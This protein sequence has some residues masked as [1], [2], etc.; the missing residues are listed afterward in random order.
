MHSEKHDA[1]TLFRDFEA[2]EKPVISNGIGQKTDAE[3]SSENSDL[4]FAP[5]LLSGA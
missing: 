4:I 2:S 5:V 3:T 1:H